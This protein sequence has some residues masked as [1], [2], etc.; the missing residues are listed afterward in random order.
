MYGCLCIGGDVPSANLMSC[1]SA[2]YNRFSEGGFTGDLY[3]CLYV[4]R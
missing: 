1:L 4:E 3:G 2:Y